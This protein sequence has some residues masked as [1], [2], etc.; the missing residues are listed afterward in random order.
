VVANSG[1]VG[2]FRT[3]YAQPLFD[4][5]VGKAASLSAADQLGLVS[6]SWALGEAGYGPVSNFLDLSRHLPVDADPL[7]W[8]RVAATFAEI[9]NLY[10]GLGARQEAFRAFARA[11]LQPVLIRIGWDAAPGDAATLAVLRETLLQTLG[12][13]DD[14]A[15]IAEARRRFQVFVIKP[16]SLDAGIRTTVL[17]IVGTHADSATFKV[18]RDMVAAAVDPQE[19]RQ[20]LDALAGVR[21]PALANQAMLMTVSQ[22]V[23]ASIAIPMMRVAA[24]RH[25]QAAWRFALDHKAVF[26]ARSDPSQKLSFIPRLLVGASDSGLADEL[27]AFAAKAY[28]EGG[29]READKVEA[30]VRFRAKVRARR[31]P[32]VDRWL[33]HKQR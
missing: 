7:V 10:D 1:Q 24:A 11:V 32:E 9:D 5:L 17:K 28:A 3:A 21:D 13:L 16:D 29:R 20:Y 8:K 23:P 22:E 4:A 18:L 27:H 33:R 15:V 31:L 26:D 25:P 2:Y 12:D 6:D 19:K 14:P 30:G